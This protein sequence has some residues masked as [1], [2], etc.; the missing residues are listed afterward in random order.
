MSESIKGNYANVIDPNIQYKET[1]PTPKNNLDKDAFLNLLVTQLRYQDPMN[2]TDDKEFI[3]QMAQFT[4]LE[5][6][7]NMNKNLESSSAFSMIGKEVKA[8]MVNE[9]TLDVEEIQGKVDAVKMKSGKTYLVVN[10]KEVPFDKV[11]AVTDSTIL[12]DTN[13]P[14]SAFELIGK[15]IQLEIENSETKQK[16]LIEGEVKYVK[17]EDGKP[18]VVIGTGDEE[19]AAPLT[20]VL[21]VVDEPTIT[22][23]IIRATVKDSETGDEKTIEGPV[24]FIRIKDEKMYVVVNGEEIS[25][26]D[27]DKVLNAD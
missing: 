3:A 6:M 26:D 25:F 10:D 24:D 2:P 12:G 18:Y 16:E 5:Q 11:E 23:K 22:G 17:M 7:Q 27:V 4:S 1:E 21:N 20:N 9:S 13:Q 19:I 14:T 15:T 8:K